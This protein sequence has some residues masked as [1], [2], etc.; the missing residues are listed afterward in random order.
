MK[1]PNER[2]KVIVVGVLAAMVVSIGSFQFVSLSG[3]IKKGPGAGV[4]SEPSKNA[5]REGDTAEKGDLVAALEH[6]S[7]AATA[8]ATPDGA[9]EELLKGFRSGRD[10]F[11]RTASG[12]RDPEAQQNAPASTPDPEPQPQP[13]RPRPPRNPRPMPEIPP[14][15]PLPG[16]F[17][18]NPGELQIT[19]GEPL[20]DLSKP[21]YTLVG[22]VVGK[23]PVAVFQDSEGNQRLVK[24]GATID[25]ESRVVSV[26]K[27]RV[28]IKHNGKNVTL[29]M[30]GKP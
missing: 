28:V 2:K 17:V 30:G 14:M 25:G 11:K 1:S 23:T 20:P 7:S 12:P 4:V 18:G 22:T 15:N 24:E 8:T 29:T 21:Q 16:S 5:P 26:D 6:N 27:G 3:T 10:P 19:P 9:T 13:T